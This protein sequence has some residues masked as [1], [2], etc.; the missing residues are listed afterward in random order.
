MNNKQYDVTVAGIATW[1]TLLSGIDEDLMSQDGIV[2]E[3]YIGASGGDAVNGAI[4]L[5]KLGMKV[6]LCAC[7]GKDSVGQAIIDDLNC[8][9][10]NTDN[11]T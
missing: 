1:D 8:A 2:C 4:N 5:A 9:G 6:T 11:V 7:I 3:N 10:V